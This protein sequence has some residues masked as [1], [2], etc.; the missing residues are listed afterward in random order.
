MSVAILA[1]T[2]LAQVSPLC[3]SLGFIRRGVGVVGTRPQSFPSPSPRHLTFPHPRFIMSCTQLQSFQQLMHFQ[4]FQFQQFM[5]FQHFQH[6]QRMKIEHH[7]RSTWTTRSTCR[8][9]PA[10]ERPPTPTR[11]EVKHRGFCTEEFTTN[12]PQAEETT[13]AKQD[14]QVKHEDFCT[15][16]FTTN[17]LQAEETTPTK[18]DQQ[19][20]SEEFNTNQLQTE[21]SNT[22]QLQTEE[23]MK[24]E[25]KALVRGTPSFI[26]IAV[27]SPTVLSL[28]GMGSTL[29]R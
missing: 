22:N 2:I 5:Q 12:Q 26:T 3:S 10:G 11:N 14:Q 17:Q 29:G 27:T 15:E 9:W 20:K 13:R 6:H 23:K 28:W 18:H 7:H 1:Q 19:A 16:E 21:E 8:T 4:Y 24:M 25:T